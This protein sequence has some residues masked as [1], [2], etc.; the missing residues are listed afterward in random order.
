MNK[1]KINKEIVYVL[2]SW[3]Q[4]ETNGEHFD[5]DLMIFSLNAKEKIISNEQFI[6]FNN[7]SS[8]CKSIVLEKQSENGSELEDE[9]IRLN[10]NS[11]SEDIMFLDII[12]SIHEDASKNFGQVKNA[13]IK[14]ENKE[15]NIL[16]KQNLSEEVSKFSFFKLRFERQ[17]NNWWIANCFPLE[18]TNLE[19]IVK[20]YGVAVKK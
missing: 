15:K 17:E 16:Y 9:K 18:R 14:V 19:E 11:L 13:I 20:S 2:L 1:I 4:R 8:Q 7:T 10:F 6:F 3:D 5:L 12:V